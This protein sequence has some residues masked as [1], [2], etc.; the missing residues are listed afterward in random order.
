[1]RHASHFGSDPADPDETKNLARNLPALV[2]MNMPVDVGQRQSPV[3]HDRH[4]LNRK[5]L[6]TIGL[7]RRSR[8]AKS[9]SCG[10]AETE[11]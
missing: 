11:W 3:A 9:S 8:D 10:I 6:R 7:V 4:A 1:M 5:S 2:A